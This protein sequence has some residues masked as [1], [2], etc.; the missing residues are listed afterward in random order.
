MDE[1]LVICSLDL[2]RRPYFSYNLNL[3]SNQE[4]DP[5]LVEHFFRSLAFSM[6][7]TLHVYQLNGK[8]PH[9]IA[10]AAFK[11]LGLSLKQ[12]VEPSQKSMSVKGSL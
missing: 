6:P 12:A 9:H 5:A 3:Q 11:A 1:A 7:M 10:E 2:V 4:F 8:D